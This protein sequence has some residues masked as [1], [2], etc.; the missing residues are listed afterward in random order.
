[1]CAIRPHAVLRAVDDLVLSVKAGDDPR[2]HWRKL[3]EA[4]GLPYGDGRIPEMGVSVAVD[5]DVPEGVVRA[6]ELV[7]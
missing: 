7:R 2:R 3:H 1:V 6:V 4:L 5:P